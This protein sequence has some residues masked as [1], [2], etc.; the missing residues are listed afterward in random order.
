MAGGVGRGIICL[1][2]LIENVFQ[3][4]SLRRLI[5]VWEGGDTS[6]AEI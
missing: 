2:D 6:N 3:I 4:N 1:L 5:K